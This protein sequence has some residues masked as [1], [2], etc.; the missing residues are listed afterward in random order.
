MHIVS[1]FFTDYMFV[2]APA[3][4][5]ETR[6]YFPTSHLPLSIPYCNLSYY[7]MNILWTV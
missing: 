3:E 5:L 2:L 6:I 7:I 1:Y 4:K